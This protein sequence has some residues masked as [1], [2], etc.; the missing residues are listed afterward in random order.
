[1]RRTQ[2]LA[3]LLLG[4]LVAC[5]GAEDG[6]TGGGGKGDDPDELPTGATLQFSR[7]DVVFTNPLCR[8]YL[9]DT[10]LPSAD[11]SESIRQKPKNVWCAKA[12]D[13]GPSAD[14]PASAQSRLVG[15]VDALGEGDEVFFA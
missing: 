8:D 10:P 4:T 7:Y 14:R 11:G 2:R 15:W 12:S 6:D 13:W 3:V 9:Y 1:M 5:G